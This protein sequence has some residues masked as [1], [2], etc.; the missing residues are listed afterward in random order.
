[1]KYKLQTIERTD[2]LALGLSTLSRALHNNQLTA[3]DVVL[4]LNELE[5]KARDLSKLL[6]L[7]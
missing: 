3:K 5:K 4:K 6:N 1:M 7:E 2:A